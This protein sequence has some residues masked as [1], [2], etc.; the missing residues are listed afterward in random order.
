MKSKMKIWNVVRYSTVI[1]LLLLYSNVI[2]SQCPKAIVCD[3]IRGLGLQYDGAIPNLNAL[4]TYLDFGTGDTRNGYYTGGDYPTDP[5]PSVRNTIFYTVPCSSGLS[6]LS[7]RFNDANHTYC[8]AVNSCSD[9]VFHKNT[10]G[11]SFFKALLDPYMN[12]LTLSGCK[13]WDGDCG[14]NGTVYRSGRLGIG[15]T[16]TNLNYLLAVSGKIMTEQYKVQPCGNVWC[17]YVFDKDYKLMPLLALD[18]F[19]KKNKR[20][21]DTK[22]AADIK[23]EDGIDAGE[24]LLNHQEK[25]EE[26]FLHLIDLEKQL[27]PHI[28][29]N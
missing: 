5:D 29:N 8:G 19:I 18:T 2:K 3:P 26:I 25:I 22:S 12:G 21:P 1:G 27:Y 14:V 23:K 11:S 16:Y 15:T 9:Y 13:Q 10:D 17:D 20:L 6:N 28:N 4:N 24:T 7:I